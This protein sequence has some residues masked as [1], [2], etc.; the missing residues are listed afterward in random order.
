MSIPAG[1]DFTPSA[2]IRRA[3]FIDEQGYTEQAEFD[4]ADEACPHLVLLD[5]D[6]PV[7]TGRVL[8]QPDGNAKLG[9]IAVLKAYRGQHLG[10]TVVRELLQYAKQHGAVYAKI[11]AQCHAIP[12]Y[13]K[14]GFQVQGEMYPDGP[15]PHRDMEMTL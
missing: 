11:S 2:L 14:F 3:V 7:A 13:E 15:I 4:A 1:D 6:T 8:L 9:R 10:E 12:F 5:G